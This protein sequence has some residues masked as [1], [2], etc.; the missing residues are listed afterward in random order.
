MLKF[1]SF[2]MW[3][4]R[5]MLVSLLFIFVI[6][7]AT[8][9]MRVSNFHYQALNDATWSKD[10]HLLVVC[11]TDGYCSLIHFARGELGTPYHGP[12]GANALVGETKQTNPVAD[13]STDPST[14]SVSE[15]VP[16]SSDPVRAC[17]DSQPV[18]VPS[19]PNSCSV[20]SIGPV[21]NIP[22]PEQSAPT[23]DTNKNASVDTTVR[24]R[25]VALTTLTVD[26]DV[27]QTKS[28]LGS[29][30]VT[31]NTPLTYISASH[32]EEHYIALVNMEKLVVKM[33][34]L[35]LP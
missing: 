6:K 31:P 33:I 30:E 14:P 19:K 12:V 24:K 8:P 4:G 29:T 23:T 10:G 15:S 25:R 28:H 1:V 32:R 3:S 26:T 27:Q 17:T 11:S 18:A 13:K 5:N 20:K 2:A 35:A 16:A 7:Y 34:F 22:K 21:P 9:T